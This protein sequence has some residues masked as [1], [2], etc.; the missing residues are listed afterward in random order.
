MFCGD[1]IVLVKELRKEINGNIKDAAA[2]I[3]Y[4]N[5]CMFNMRHTL[6]LGENRKPC[7]YHKS[8]SLSI[9]A[10]SYKRMEKWKVM[11]TIGLKEEST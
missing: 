5:T 8:H 7:P 11:Y 9:L 6:Q 1:D 2:D 4:G 3:S 10:P